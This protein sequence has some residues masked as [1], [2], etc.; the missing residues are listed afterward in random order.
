M[1]QQCMHYMNEYLAID[2]G[3]NAYEHTSRI[4]CTNGG[5]LLEKLK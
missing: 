2:S 3:G 4:N 1:C 5:C